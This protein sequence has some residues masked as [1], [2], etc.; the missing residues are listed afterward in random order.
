MPDRFTRTML[1]GI[2]ILLAALVARP[3]I[4]VALVPPTP[5]PVEPRGNL[6]DCLAAPIGSEPRK[7]ILETKAGHCDPAEF[8]DRYE[9][10]VVEML[11]QET[12]RN[13][14]EEGNPGRQL[15]NVVNLM[16]ALRRSI[17]AERGM[18]KKAKAPEKVSRQMGNRKAGQWSASHSIGEWVLAVD[19]E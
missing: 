6:A 14:G 3:Y 13:A 8:D 17:Q 9:N 12:S 15:R 7:H 10:A 5:R 11:K 18:G 2:L 4:E 19:Q 1:F 16:D